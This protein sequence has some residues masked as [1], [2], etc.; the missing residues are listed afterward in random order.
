MDARNGDD[1]A[2]PVERA[3]II[4]SIPV[5]ALESFAAVDMEQLARRF[6]GQTVTITEPEPHPFRHDAQGNSLPRARITV[7]GPAQ[8]QVE[9][10]QP[11]R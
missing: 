1:P 3:G 7:T 11:A 6:E 4:V 2:T 10:S 5:T 8:I 9:G